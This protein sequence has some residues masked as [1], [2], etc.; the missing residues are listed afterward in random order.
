M[1]R[2]SPGLE[3]LG[4]ARSTGASALPHLSQAPNVTLPRGHYTE[5]VGDLAPVE[6]ARGTAAR[7]G[8]AFVV[9]EVRLWFR[10][11]RRGRPR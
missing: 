6:R 5:D 9:S 4:G 3:Q 2:V 1:R 10:A 8:D 7:G 11:L